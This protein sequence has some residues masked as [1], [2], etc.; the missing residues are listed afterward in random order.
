M[1]KKDDLATQNG[2]LV[3]YARDPIAALEEVIADAGG[4]CELARSIC[5][6][7]AD[8]NHWK[9]KGAVPMSKALVIG[10]LYDAPWT[11]LVSDEDAMWISLMQLE[12]ALGNL[13]ADLVKLQTQ[14]TAVIDT[15][16]RLRGDKITT[17]FSEIV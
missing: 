1:K 10:I 3:S 8:I 5:V 15:M 4:I 11:P 2:D 7:T 16:F 13:Q 12:N 17:P 9:E 6:S 14:T